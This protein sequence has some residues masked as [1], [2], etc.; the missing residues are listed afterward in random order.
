MSIQP[1]RVIGR[2]IDQVDQSDWPP[3]AGRFVASAD[4]TGVYR[5]YVAPQVERYATPFH[6]WVHALREERASVGRRE[7]LVGAAGHA[8]CRSMSLA[9]F[10]TQ[11][12][13]CELA[14][15]ANAREIL[16]LAAIP[17]AVVAENA[18]IAARRG[19]VAYEMLDSACRRSGLARYGGHL[20]TYFWGHGFAE[21]WRSGG[22]R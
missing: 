22:V 10:L 3:L 14:E 9:D 11:L 8:M 2:M 1:V 12:D 17:D 15:G 21:S 4:E 20:M 6:F 19:I 13:G 5:F 16:G 18:A 7:D